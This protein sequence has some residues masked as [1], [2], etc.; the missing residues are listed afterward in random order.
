M[1]A[2]MLAKVVAEI[3]PAAG[4]VKLL[5]DSIDGMVAALPDGIAMCQ[6]VGSET[7][8]EA[9]RTAK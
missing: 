3:H 2:R 7:T 4:L 1:M 9:E 6:H 5:R 8:Y